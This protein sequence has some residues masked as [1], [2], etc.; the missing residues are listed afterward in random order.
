MLPGTNDSRVRF[1]RAINLIVATG[2]VDLF[3]D[4][5]EA[6]RAVC[7]CLGGVTA[8]ESAGSGNGRDARNGMGALVSVMGEGELAIQAC[9]TTKANAGRMPSP[10]YPSLVVEYQ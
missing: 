10:A 1:H 5:H 8:A 2:L 4:M 9:V 6:P 7:R 3:V